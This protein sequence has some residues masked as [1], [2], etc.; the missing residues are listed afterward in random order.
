MRSVVP[1]L[2]SLKRR[3]GASRLAHPVTRF[4]TPNNVIFFVLMN[5]TSTAAMVNAMEK[6]Q[7]GACAAHHASYGALSRFG[8]PF[9]GTSQSRSF[10]QAEC[11][12]VPQNTLLIS[13]LHSLEAHRK[14]NNKEACSA[15][16]HQHLQT[17]TPLQ[18]IKPSRDKEIM[19]TS[20]SEEDKNT[21]MW[22]VS[23][24]FEFTPDAVAWL[25]DQIKRSPAV[26]STFFSKVSNPNKPN[27]QVD[28][29]AIITVAKLLGK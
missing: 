13:R 9:W 23:L 7:D 1:P 17:T 19:A 3:A 11:E 26:H 18:G 21:P 22:A 16:Q 6:A 28:S 20:I 14:S 4:S 5:V 24:A 2:R 8:P 12:C 25:I 27:K 15:L 29:L 10:P